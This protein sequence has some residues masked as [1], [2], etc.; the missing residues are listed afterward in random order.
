MLV[1]LS[2]GVVWDH[3]DAVCSAFSCIWVEALTRKHQTLVNVQDLLCDE[4]MGGETV[5]CQTGRLVSLP[6]DL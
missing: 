6:V 2:N 4:V 3:I 1:P 5:Q